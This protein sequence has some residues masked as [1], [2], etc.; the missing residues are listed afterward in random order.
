M[1]SL[2]LFLVVVAPV[3]RLLLSWIYVQV[4]QFTLSQKYTEESCYLC[5]ILSS[6]SNDNKDEKQKQKKNFSMSLLLVLMSVCCFWHIFLSTQIQVITFSLESSRCLFVFNLPTPRD[7]KREFPMNK[8]NFTNKLE[9]FIDRTKVSCREIASTFLGNCSQQC[10]WMFQNQQVFQF[11]NFLVFRMKAPFRIWL[12]TASSRM[13]SS[14][15]AFHLPPSKTSQFRFVRGAC[16]MPISSWTLQCR[17][18]LVKLYSLAEFHV[19]WKLVSL[20]RNIFEQIF[21]FKFCSGTRY[22]YGPFVWWRLLR[23]HRYWPRIEISK[24]KIQC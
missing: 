19:R 18:I 1:T 16:Q 9:V 20:K 2:L 3:S 6:P 15:F 12:K 4:P 5:R 22:D 8:L 7:A 11:P 23:W 14:T 17:W 21:N 13:K 10:V 24:G